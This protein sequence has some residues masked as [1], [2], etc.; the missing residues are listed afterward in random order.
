MDAQSIQTL[1]QVSTARASVTMLDKLWTQIDVLDDVKAM[2]E[3]VK[4]RGS[5]FTENFTGLL[6]QLKESQQRLMEV[7]AKHTEKSDLNRE[8]RRSGARE[9][10][11]K[12]DFDAESIK[13]E[14]EDTKKRM[15][16]FFFGQNKDDD[17][18]QRRDVEELGE[19]V[20]DVR[21]HMEE[22]GDRMLK[23]DEE[24]KKLW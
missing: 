3:E 20:G 14:S 11:E 18:P 10:I 24:I 5:F 2:A 19:Y 22:V 12:A 13:R 15:H 16:E 9:N 4:A 17:N 23:F 6:M 21:Q 8:Q 1:E 7:M